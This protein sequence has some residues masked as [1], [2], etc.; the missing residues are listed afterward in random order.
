[1]M[2]TFLVTGGTGRQGG[3]ALREILKAGAKVHALVRNPDSDAAEGIARLGATLF[4]GDSADA[5]S[6][7]KALEGVDGVFFNPPYPGEDTLEV[8]QNFIKACAQQSSVKT[9]VL[10]STSGTEKHVEKIQTDPT[11]PGRQKKFMGYW[12]LKAGTEDAARMAGFQNLVILRAS[13]LHHIYLPPD[14]RAL[15]P[16]LWTE[17]KLVTALKPDTKVPHLLAEDVGKFAAVALLD[18]S[19]FNSKELNLA[20]ENL[21]AEDVTSIIG[22]VAGRSFEAVVPDFNGIEAIGLEYPLAGYHEWCNEVD[23]AVDV[24]AL[25]E[26]GIEL[27]IMRQFLEAH[28]A[29]VLEALD[30]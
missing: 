8:T 19:K 16:T 30:T 20:A 9:F 11:Y 28:Q 2:S 15:F 7:T 13:L 26:Y 3:S 29:D 18:P 14:S 10:S 12:N 27:T 1:M 4:K 5:A 24:A 25:K 23:A 6:V 17:K 22:A 21:T